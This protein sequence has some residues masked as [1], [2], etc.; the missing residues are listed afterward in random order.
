[1]MKIRTIPSITVAAWLALVAAASGMAPRPESLSMLVVPARYTM[2]Q[3]AFDVAA[4]FPAVLVAY[5]GV[6]TS[7]DPV[8]HVWDG[9]D[10]IPVTLAD[11]EQA[12]FL[13]RLPHRVILVG[14]DEL[15][16]P[17][18]ITKAGW[19]PS[20][21]NVEA[22]DPP[23]ILNALGGVLDFSRA[24][25]NWF[26]GR[27]GLRVRDAHVP[28]RRDSWYSLPYDEALGF[29][30]PPE[31][32]P[33][34]YFAEPELPRPENEQLPELPP[35]RFPPADPE[36]FALPLPEEPGTGEAPIK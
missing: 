18:L 20:V 15:L 8:L 2:C 14:D 7:P 30:G 27:Y 31:G 28:F 12:S 25:W 26:A 24:D 13:T 33:E 21:F 19:A 36:A 5:Q 22:M 10:W 16:P 9:R 23:G 35:V 1:M 3:I 32:D 4:R 11:Y 34:E 29:H 6:A 17:A